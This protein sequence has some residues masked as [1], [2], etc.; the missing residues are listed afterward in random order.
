MPSASRRSRA[1]RSALDR[2]I[3]LGWQDYLLSLIGGSLA[4][5]SVGMAVKSNEVILYFIGAFALGTLLSFVM[6]RFAKPSWVKVEGVLLLTVALIAAF[7]TKNLVKPFGETFDS[8]FLVAGTM[9][10]I[11]IFFS[12]VSFRD[13]SLLFQAVPS[14]ALFGLVGCYDT[15]REAAVL[16]GFFLIS[17]AVLFARIHTRTNYEFAMNSGVL[18]GQAS[19]GQNNY[20]SLKAG[21]WRA[22]AGPQW[23]FYSAAVIMLLSFVGAPVVQFSVQ[24]VAGNV[25]LNLPNRANANPNRNYF[26]TE[27]SAVQVGRGPVRLGDSPLYQVT[28]DRFLYYRLQTYDRW[29]GSGWAGSIRANENDYIRLVERAMPDRRVERYQITVITSGSNQ[30]PVAGEKADVP[31]MAARTASDGTLSFATAGNVP[32]VTSIEAEFSNREPSGPAVPLQETKFAPYTDASRVPEDVANWAREVTQ[33]AKTDLEKANRIREAVRDRI[34]YD[35]EA[36]AVPAGSDAVSHTLFEAKRGYCDVFASSVVLMCRAVGIPARYVTG[37]IP[38]AT[39]P[40]S[41]GRFLIRENGSHAWAEVLLQDSGWVVMDATEGAQEAEGRGRRTNTSGGEW[42]LNPSFWIGVGSLAV[43][44]ALWLGLRA[45]Q[46]WRKSMNPQRGMEGLVFDVT[47]WVGKRVDRGRLAY[48]SPAE[49][50]AAV[51]DRIPESHATEVVAII[52]EA[53]RYLF[54]PIEP[55]DPD[56]ASLK[57]RWKRVK[58]LWQKEPKKKPVEV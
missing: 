49:F 26:R 28:I 33:G 23:A 4:L 13:T 11:L 44:I 20:E 43:C 21:P 25:R 31:G 45:F 51:R 27:Q 1:G 34:V 38:D 57:E 10:F 19:A 8:V 16:F 35:T 53:E 18:D 22:M 56:V 42:W 17:I 30:V 7:G 29:T 15:F 52:A 5:Y 47:D 41:D 2:R 14:I 24:S 37:F 50:V 36:G 55:Q 3:A 48:E 6:S 12:F 58:D 39:E 40:D 46:R 32:P 54:G 9:S